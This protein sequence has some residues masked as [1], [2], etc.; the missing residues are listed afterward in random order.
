MEQLFWN[1]CE[2]FLNFSTR[3]HYHTL[4]E[5]VDGIHK[6]NKN[7]DL[8]LIPEMAGNYGTLT[9]SVQISLELYI[10]APET[11]LPSEYFITVFSYELW[12]AIFLCI[13]SVILFLFALKR[14][15]NYSFNSYIEFIYY[16]FGISQISFQYSSLSFNCC[17]TVTALFKFVISSSFSA[18]LITE[19]LN[20][21]Y[22]LPFENLSEIFQQNKYSL[23]VFHDI[24]AFPRIMFN[25]GNSSG[26]MNTRKCPEFQ[27]NKPYPKYIENICEN[28][29]CVFG[30][31]NYLIAKDIR[32]RQKYLL[33][34]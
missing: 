23:C 4:A 13:F 11:I 22:D 30:Y 5:Y 9:P 16:V 7:L 26:I 21:D 18:F 20:L 17:H 24:H 34:C 29:Y 27:E 28:P 6:F 33:F 32:K 1:T 19:L 31:L 25:Y 10:K 14:I 15:F 12:L 2:E 8:V 3:Y